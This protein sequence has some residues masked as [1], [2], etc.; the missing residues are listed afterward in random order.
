MDS[1]Q[2]VCVFWDFTASDGKGDWSAQG[3]ETVTHN[4]TVTCLCNH[5]THFALAR[6]R[7]A[8][9]SCSCS[10]P[11]IIYVLFLS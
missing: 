8:F 2:V 10:I 5:L 7:R 9:P 6:V 11:L 4:G 3:C 1:S